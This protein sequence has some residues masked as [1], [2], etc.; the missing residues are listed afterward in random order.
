MS[1][2]DDDPGAAAPEEYDK[3]ADFD[4]PFVPLASFY[5]ATPSLPSG[6][7]AV[8]FDSRQELLHVGYHTGHYRSFTMPGCESYTARQVSYTPVSHIAPVADGCL[9][10]AHD[11]LKIQT[12]RGLTSW[13]LTAKD[14]FKSAG[15]LAMCPLMDSDHPISSG[16]VG[17]IDTPYIAVAATFARLAIV[18]AERG[19][20]VRELVP[21]DSPPSETH[22]VCAPS[23][24]TLLTANAAGTLK[25][26]DTRAWRVSVALSVHPGPFASVVP[27]SDHLILTTGMHTG[28]AVVDVVD[29]RA[30]ALLG[31]IG[32]QAGLLARASSTSAI[33]VS[34]AGH[35]SLLHVPTLQVSSTVELWDSSEMDTSAMDPSAPIFSCLDVSPSGELVA[36]GDFHGQLHVWA[37]SRSDPL[38][39]EDG[40]LDWYPSTPPVVTYDPTP[41]EV[42][43]MIVP[44]ATDLPWS[45]DVPLGTH[46]G[47]PYY[48][49]PLLSGD[50]PESLV[51]SVGLPPAV[52]PPTIVANARAVVN[53]VPGAAQL[54]AAPKPS[55]LLRNQWPYKSKMDAPRFKSARKMR[56]RSRSPS[57]SASRGRTGSQN[58][59]R[60]AGSALGSVVDDY[61]KHEIQ[62]SRF[63]VQDFDFKFFNAT[64]Y[65][66]LETAV[67]QSYVNNY[68]QAL[69]FLPRFRSLAISHSLSP[70]CTKVLCLL[71]ETGYLFRQLEQSHG[72]GAVCRASNW[73]ST[74]GHLRETT[75][76]NLRESPAVSFPS[77]AATMSAC[78]RFL[79]DQFRRDASDLGGM[80][81]SP[82]SEFWLQLHTSSECTVCNVTREKRI[83]TYAIDL[84]YPGPR[85]AFPDL[86]FVDVLRGAIAGTG[87]LASIADLDKSWCTRCRDYCPTATRRVPTQLPQVLHLGC[88][89]KGEWNADWWCT[90]DATFTSSQTPPFLP[91]RIHLRIADDGSEALVDEA[92]A[93]A[94]DD[95]VYILSAIIF[96]VSEGRPHVASHIYTEEQNKWYLF[97]DFRVREIPESQALIFPKWAIPSVIHYRRLETSVRDFSISPSASLLDPSTGDLERLLEPRQVLNPN[98]CHYLPEPLRAMELFGPG[99]VCA[100][101]AEFVSLCEEQAE[102]ASDGTKRVTRP[103]DLALARVSVVRGTGQRSG[104]VCIDDYVEPRDPIEDYVT[105][106]SGIEPSDLDRTNSSRNLVTLKTAYRKLRAMVDCGA[107]F[108]GHSLE[109]DFRIINLTV[110]PSQVVDTVALYHIPEQQRKLSLKFLAWAVLGK[111]V[112]LGNHDSVEDARTALSLYHRYLEVQAT[113]RWPEFLAEI[114]DIGH[115]HSFRP[116]AVVDSVTA[117]AAATAAAVAAAQAAAVANAAASHGH[118]H[119]HFQPMPTGAPASALPLTHP[120]MLMPSLPPHVVHAHMAAAHAYMGQTHVHSAL[121]G[122]P[123]PPVHPLSH[124]PHL[125]P[126]HRHHHPDLHGAH[127]QPQQHDQHFLQQ[128]QHQHQLADLHQQRMMEA[129]AFVT[130]GVPGMHPHMRPGPDGYA[131]AGY[132]DY[133]S[134]V[135]GRGHPP[136][137]EGP[138]GPGGGGGLLPSSHFGPRKWP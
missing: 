10:L 48:D 69:Y 26:L 128:Q 114:Y 68:L 56:S 131:S 89:V 127:L 11:A 118:G 6:L 109:Q 43:S 85:S 52:I 113:G 9:L 130:H 129:P 8:R 12:R 133:A 86:R 132:L 104:T 100:I 41:V 103:R 137:V 135:A 13:S 31:S 40:M 76:M 106:F 87:G 121:H 83:D 17:N 112:Q 79:T 47:M 45:D 5:A 37:R 72:V 120:M 19:A 71:C 39:D 65:A 92:A 136:V 63:G 123:P 35:L 98:N 55:G 108:V 115:R 30:Q 81:P 34:D 15:L 119:V 18:H 50:W 51:H 80:M 46:V 96:E 124:L 62:Y 126:H 14:D 61:K 84:A 67:P 33:A 2:F 105:A 1:S 3:T 25:L 27:I 49:A 93:G 91:L 54:K 22:F 16:P 125:H 24:H 77:V 44:S 21:S 28:R 70:N 20:I 134:V 95:D 101:D 36:L 75:V 64:P 94:T 90:K 122:P 78:A 111:H 58:Q 60:S 42:P 29:I 32:V 138:P 57:R 23:P 117:V 97:N 107:I 59:A 73:C 38:V 116:P 7:S 66:G 110:P 4:V 74:F 88:N 102:F 99:F 82:S 53:A